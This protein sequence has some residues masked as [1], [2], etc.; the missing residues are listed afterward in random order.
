MYDFAAP[1]RDEV[2]RGVHASAAT[3]WPLFTRAR[4]GVPPVMPSSSVASSQS[5]VVTIR[6]RLRD[7]RTLLRQIVV[8][9]LTDRDLHYFGLHA[10]SSCTSIVMHIAGAVAPVQPTARL[11]LDVPHPTL[12]PEVNAFRSRAVHH[13]TWAVRD[14]AGVDMFCLPAFWR[15]AEWRFQIGRLRA[16]Q[17]PQSNSCPSRHV[18]GNA[19]PNEGVGSDTSGIALPASSPFRPRTAVRLRL[20]PWLTAAPLGPVSLHVWCDTTQGAREKRI[21]AILFRSSFF[22]TPRPAARIVHCLSRSFCR[23]LRPSLIRDFPPEAIPSCPHTLS[24]VV[25]KIPG[26]EETSCGP[27]QLGIFSY[28]R[29]A[30]RRVLADEPTHAIAPRLKLSPHAQSCARGIPV[31]RPSRSRR[32]RAARTSAQQHS[33]QYNYQDPNA[34]PQPHRRR[35]ASRDTVS[36]VRVP[37]PLRLSSLCFTPARSPLRP[38]SLPWLSRSLLNRC[39]HGPPRR[40]YE[41]LAAGCTRP[42]LFRR[43]DDASRFVARFR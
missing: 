20:I 3:L 9:R 37:L 38:H 10:G 29:E 4:Y 13:P 11:L 1:M 19:R 24:R 16:I 35:P 5:G 33:S 36:F 30:N 41:F 27:S 6:T 42:A 23:A 25:E 34:R 28:T 40:R 2:V 32:L 43:L 7:G 18:Q 22:V 39:S 12:C 26:G 15:V 14:G 21:G 31:A 17:L 8:V